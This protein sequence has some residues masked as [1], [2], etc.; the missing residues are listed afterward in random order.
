M[1][2]GDFNSDFTNSIRYFLVLNYINVMAKHQY[3]KKIIKFAN[4]FN[5]KQ[6]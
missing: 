1:Y 6:I 3:N 2:S 4:V 5:E